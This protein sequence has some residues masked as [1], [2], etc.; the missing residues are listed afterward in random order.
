MDTTYIN[1]ANTNQKVFEKA[2]AETNR[3]R[4]PDNLRNVQSFTEYV[5]QQA[6]RLLGHIIRAPNGDHMRQVCL[7]ANTAFPRLPNKRRVGRPRLHWTIETMKRCWERI[8]PEL[9]DTPDPV[10]YDI[11]SQVVSDNIMLGAKRYYV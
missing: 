10:P 5:D 2:I 3:H 8:E 6:I 4:P 9:Y 11:R 1:R 7:R